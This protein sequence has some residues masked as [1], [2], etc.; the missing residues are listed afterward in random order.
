VGTMRG[1]SGEIV[2]MAGRRRLDFC[3]LQETRWKGGSSRMLGEEKRK[4][5]FIWIGSEKGDAGVGVLIAEKWL[6]KLK[7]VKRVN[8]RIL[9][10][11]VQF[12]KSMLNLIS[13][14]APQV[15]R[16]NTEK[17]DFWA[18][19]LMLVCSIR[20]EEEV[21]I[22]GDMNGHVGSGMDG[23]E[24]VHG[25]HGYGERN[26]EGEMLLEFAMATGMVLLNT[27]FQKSD[28]KKVTYASGGVE[29]VVDYLLIRKI[30]KHRVRDVKVIPGEECLTQHRLLVGCVSLGE[31]LKGNPKPGKCNKRLRV[32]RLKDKVNKSQFQEQ[33]LMTSGMDHDDRSA[34]EMWNEMKGS[35]LRAT[36]EVCRKTSG[37]IRRRKG[38]WWWNDEVAQAVKNKRVLYKV[39]FRSKSVEDKLKYQEAKRV[40]RRVVAKAQSETRKELV[41]SLDSA[42][43]KGQIFRLVKQMVRNNSDL[44]VDGWVRNRNGEVARDSQEMKD[45][46]KDYYDKLLN[47]EFSWDRSTLDLGGEVAGPIM[48]IT[49]AEV[50]GALREMKTGKASGPSGVVS[51]MLEAAGGVGIRWLTDLFNKIILDGKMPSDWALS[52]M[53]SVYKGK[54][55]ALDCGSYRGIK[56][57][58]HAMKVFER[59]VEKRLRGSVEIDDMQ[60]GFRP[61]RGTTDAIFIVRQLQEKFL[62]KKRGLWMAFIDLEKAFDRVPREVLWWA[63][64]KLNVTEQ[65]VEVIMLMY[66]GVRT[67]V[68]TAE[69]AG[70]EFE[71][72]VGVHQGSVLSPLLF[73]IVL[74][75]ISKQ[76]RGGLPWELLYADDLVLIAETEEQLLSKIK[77]WKDSLESKGLK[78]NVGK[79]KVMKCGVDLKKSVETGKWPCG[80]CKKG[81]GRNSIKCQL[82]KKWIHKKC[83]GLSGRLVEGIKYSC[84]VCTGKRNIQPELGK[85]VDAVVLQNDSFEGVDK[86]CYLGDMIGAGG[87][88]E[89]AVRLRVKLA[90][91]KFRQLCP[92]LTVRGASLVMKGKIYCACVR[93]VMTYGSATWPLKVEDRMRLERAENMMV[94]WMCGVTLK[95][96]ISTEILRKRL[97]IGSVTNF[98]TR[99]RLGWFGHVERRAESDCLRVCQN[100]VVDGSRGRGR[101]R[102]TW[103]QCV[104]EDLREFGLKREDAL[105]RE[106]WRSKVFGGPV[107][108]V[109]ARKNRR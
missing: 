15:G 108:P 56:L 23:F 106:I 71:V 59:V 16:P 95:D 24:G 46:W 36:E 11:R 91:S 68:K 102:K 107:K 20:E 97:G 25:G 85:A 89:D 26:R 75:A 66:N 100:L 101:G 67:A 39:W 31:S 60:F 80:I 13:V 77:I 93:S 34:D 61:G 109:Q 22:G 82:C 3:C 27:F 74:E 78:V 52:W 105:N 84:G 81:V 65:L 57:L 6:E 19:L 86:F 9:L 29:S 92:I 37:R 7:E 69:G 70:E 14:Y 5:K 55:D 8:E 40:A 62:E 45:I 32:W 2:E 50:I 1:R 33:L 12:G 104:N 103:Q 88:A 99:G 73:T 21:L 94:R 90:W 96:K 17:E 10:I 51:E 18:T 35:L 43:G 87:E 79:S 63:L 49:E 42:E 47:E 4:Y 30:K 54:G 28:K 48:N 64:R 98:V 76:S 53:V 38:T 58:E 72:R 44:L 41:E 83:S